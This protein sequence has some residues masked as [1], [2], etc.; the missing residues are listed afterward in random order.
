MVLSYV[1]ADFAKYSD[2]G[3]SI[4]GYGFKVL[5]GLVSWKATL[6][7]VVALSKTEAECIV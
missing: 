2:R 1:D 4:T 5:G 7:K 3:R 6:Y